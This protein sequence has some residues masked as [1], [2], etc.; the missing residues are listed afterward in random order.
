MAEDRKDIKQYLCPACFAREIDVFLN[1]D[2]KDDEYY[3]IKCCY[4]GNSKDI[5]KFYNSYRQNK[6]KDADKPIL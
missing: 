6:F 1:Y 3:C 2:N 5:E 4:C